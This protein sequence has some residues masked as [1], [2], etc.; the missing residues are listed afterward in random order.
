MSGHRRISDVPL[1]RREG[2]FMTRSRR[3][4]GYREPLPCT[5]ALARVPHRAGRHGC[6]RD[7]VLLAVEWWY[8][9]PEFGGY[10]GNVG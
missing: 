4:G 6:G 1:A 3:S 2:R 8:D 5:S 7:A 10:P 9:F